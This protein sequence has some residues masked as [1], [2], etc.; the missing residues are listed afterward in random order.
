MK[1]SFYHFWFS[2]ENTLFCLE[3]ILLDKLTPND[4]FVISFD[5][6]PQNIFK[7][8]FAVFFENLHKRTHSRTFNSLK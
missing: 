5:I 2:W 6:Y 8:F 7:I 3:S 1:I 4:I